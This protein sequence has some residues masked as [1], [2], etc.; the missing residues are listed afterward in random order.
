MNKNILW[1]FFLMLSFII[2]CEDDND[3]FSGDDNFITSFTLKQ[4]DQV[5]VASFR[6]DTILLNMPENVSFS[7][8]AAEGVLDEILKS[9]KCP[10]N[11][12]KR[13]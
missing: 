13:R 8:L 2:G 7:G 4:G 5:F 11:E 6:G 9:V 12:E 10:E 1:G 3:P